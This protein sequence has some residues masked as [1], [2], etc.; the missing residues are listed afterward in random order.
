VGETNLPME[1]IE[2]ALSHYEINSLDEM[3][4]SQQESFLNYLE[5]IKDKMR[6]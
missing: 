4:E 6:N 3:N 2:K 1:R 5:R